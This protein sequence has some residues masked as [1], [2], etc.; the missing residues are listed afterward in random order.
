M[1]EVSVR[2]EVLEGWKRKPRVMVRQACPEPD[3]VAH[4]ERVLLPQ[5]A[6][7]ADYLYVIAGGSGWRR[8]PVIAL[9]PYRRTTAAPNLPA[10]VLPR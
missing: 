7:A 9:P 5:L 2:P 3:E 1:V 4:H 10:S 8:E 6:L